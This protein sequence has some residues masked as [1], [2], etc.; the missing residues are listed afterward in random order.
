MVNLCTD[1]YKSIL[2]HYHDGIIKCTTNST[3]IREHW[4]MAVYTSW[5]FGEAWE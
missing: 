3:H 5:M 1:D 4:C 2:P